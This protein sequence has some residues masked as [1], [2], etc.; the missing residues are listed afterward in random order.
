MRFDK[1]IIKYIVATAILALSLYL[2]ARQIAFDD[3]IMQL[4][5]LD[6]VWVLYSIPVIIA[7]NIIRALRWREIHTP[8]S[9]E[10]KTHNAFSAIMIGHLLNSFTLR[11]GE[12]A[13]PII[14][15]KKEKLPFAAVISTAVLEGGVD[16]AFLIILFFISLVF[17]SEP[18]FKLLN[19]DSVFQG[20]LGIFIIVLVVITALFFIYRYRRQLWQWSKSILPAKFAS[21]LEDSMSA[22]VQGFVSL[23]NPLFYFKMTLYTILLWLSYALIMYLVSFAFAFQSAIQ[24]SFID[25]IILVVFA[26]IAT[27]IAF[28]PGAVGVYHLVVASIMTTL[29]SITSNEA[30]AYATIIHIITLLVQSCIG[31]IYLIYEGIS[32]IKLGEMKK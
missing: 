9:T 25:S 30:F 19:F 29:Y 6:Y 24:L 28:T 18:L 3:L 5:G 16:F 7:S 31:A 27:A 1:K 10:V 32:T 4:Q 12:L 11:F 23:R 17:L 21:K 22:F 15:A 2:S 20:S 26:G 8:L 14:L 13:R